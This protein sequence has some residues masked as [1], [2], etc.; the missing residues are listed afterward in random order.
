MDQQQLSTTITLV[1]LVIF[2]LVF[3]FLFIRPQKKKDKEI[4]KMRNNLQVGDNVTTAG[5][6]VGRIVT[7]KEDTVVIETGA[8]R[9]K[10]KFLKTSV[11][12]CDTV[13]DD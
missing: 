12:T 10:I 3:Y 6:I 4:S 9:T 5:G 7:V 8:D 13:H 1:F 2:I 11:A